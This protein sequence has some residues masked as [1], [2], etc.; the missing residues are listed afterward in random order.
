MEATLG[1]GGEECLATVR[2]QELRAGQKEP[3]LLSL[4]ERSGEFILGVLATPEAVVSRP[5]AQLSI[6]INGK[7]ELV[8]EAEEA[9]LINLSEDSPVRLR[10]K[11]EKAP[12]LLLELQ[13]DDRTQTFLTQVK[14]VQQQ[15]QTKL[16]KPKAMEPFTPVALRGPVPIPPQR[17]NKAANAVSSGINQTKLTSAVP[18]NVI[19]SLSGTQTKPDPVQMLASD[20]GFEDS[21]SNSLKVEEK[22]NHQN[23]IV[24]PRQQPPIPPL[25]PRKA[26]Y[27]P[28][29]PPPPPPVAKERAVP[30]QANAFTP[31]AKPESFTSGFESTDRPLSWCDSP[32]SNTMRQAMFSSQAG[33]REYLIKHRL[34]KKESEYVDI[35]TFRLFTGT[36]NVNGQSPDS[37]LEPWLCCDTDPPDIYALGFQELDLSTEAFFYMDSSKEQLWV[38]AVERSLHPKAK[39]KRVR[40]IRLVGMMLVVFV[41]KSLRNYMKEVA[42]EHVGTG[43]MGKMGNKGGVAVRFVFHNT[44]FCIVNSHLAAHVDDFERRNQDYKDICA[45]MTFHLLDHPPL[46]IVKHDVVFW[47]GDL[48]YRLFMYDAAEVKQLIAKRELKMLQE[49]DQLNIQRQTKRAFTDFT[50]GEINFLPTYKY[51][52]KTDRWDSSGKCRVPA[53]CDR[54][55][56]RGNSVKQ[57]KYRSHMDLQTSDHKP[58]SSL[59]EIGVKVVNEERQKKVFEEI[60]RAMDRMENE[61]LPSV[62]LSRREFTFENVKFRRLQ[63]DRFLITND[64]QVPCHFA[65]I[66]KLN[67]SQYCKPWLRA[68]PSDGFLEPNETLEI[69]LEVYVSKDAVTLLNSSEDSIEE[70]L[71]LH[72]DRGKDYFITISGNYLPSCFGTSLETLCRMKKPI[73]EIPIT[74]LIDLGEDSYMDKERSKVNFLTVEGTCSEEKPLKI[75]KEV[76]IL[77]NH[78]YTK[79]CD[80]E[81]LFQTPGLQE[82]MQNIIDSLDTSIPDTISGCN[83]SVAEVLLIFLEALPEPVVCY[84]LYQRCLDCNHDSRLC[85]QLV[86]Q[87]PSAHRNVFRYLMAFLK[88]LLK[89]SH[90]NNLTASLLAT[91][92][93]SLLIRP[94]PNLAGRQTQQDRQKAIDFILGFL[95]AGDEE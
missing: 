54:I 67:D 10:V 31:N 46:S 55:L 77:V 91:L 26:P 57:L 74:K 72:L 84:E 37:T 7:F 22:K 90:N 65:F 70:I 14:S 9:L 86:S 80:Q 12:E 35:K 49:F 16:V 93:A 50:E 95:M 47:L 73:R 33:Q 60:V 39:Y 18:P 64:G 52:P 32:T 62:S 51:D 75:P 41:K 30:I 17:A 42:A 63:K 85:K 58:V 21:F 82:E 53:W 29:N 81:D 4:I 88:E 38:E 45:R 71:V 59:F 76:W 87:L 24:P 43:I 11:G 27:V 94:P 20:F 56:W 79:A 28:S 19:N 89:H 69:Y 25:P 1:I 13:D 3:R 8:R 92:F 78:L 6:P 44:S 61:F 36:W 66:P 15:V 48:N 2:G 23:R 5:V 83:H 40:I 34:G 68:E